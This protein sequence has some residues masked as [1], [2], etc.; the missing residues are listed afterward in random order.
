MQAEVVPFL[1]EMPKA[2]RSSDLVV[3]RAGAMTLAE[4]TVCGKPA[5]LIPLPHAML[6]VANASDADVASPYELVAVSGHS[7]SALNRTLVLR[8][9]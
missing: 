8:P 4:L 6:A 7:P 3:S 2:L 9:S 5:V 1:F